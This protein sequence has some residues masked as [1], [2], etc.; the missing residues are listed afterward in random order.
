MPGR[1]ADVQHPASGP[2]DWAGFDPTNGRQPGPDYVVLAVGRD[3]ADVSPMRGVLHGGA[4]H[5]LNVGVTVQPFDELPAARRE[6]L[7]GGLGREVIPM[8]DVPTASVG[9]VPPTVSSPPK[10][11]ESRP[12]PMPDNR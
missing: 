2:G 8:S 3:F 1:G 10:L 7:L 5:V 12:A 6:G 11:D 4:R 9:P